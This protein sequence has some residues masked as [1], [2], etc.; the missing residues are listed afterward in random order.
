M[1][2]NITAGSMVRTFLDSAPLF[3]YKKLAAHF[4]DYLSSISLR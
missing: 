4:V 3:S 1:V 2:D